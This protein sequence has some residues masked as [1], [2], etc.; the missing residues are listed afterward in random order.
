MPYSCKEKRRRAVF[1]KKFKGI[2]P[3]MVEVEQ[4][5][6][7]FKPWDRDGLRT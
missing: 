6:A 3:G 2:I 1:M 4:V 5:P 7:G